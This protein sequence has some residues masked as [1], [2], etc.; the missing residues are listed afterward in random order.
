M[1]RKFVNVLI[2]LLTAAVIVV[3]YVIPMVASSYHISGLRYDILIITI[4]AAVIILASGAFEYIISL[5]LAEFLKQ[6]EQTWSTRGSLEILPKT[7]QPREMVQITNTISA[8]VAANA[9]R[10]SELQNMAG[11]TETYQRLVT[12][13]SHQMRTPVTGLNW[14][15]TSIHDDIAKGKL[16]DQSLVDEAHQA[17]ERIGTL[18]EELLVGISEQGSAKPEYR[19]IDLEECVDRI[20]SESDL[21]AKQRQIRFAVTKH[22]SPLP[23]IHGNEQ[24]IRFALHS[25]ITNAIYYSNEGGT[26]SITAES[27]GKN[28]SIT[29][30]N[31]GPAIMENEKAVIFS[32]FGRSDRAIRVNPD[33]SGLGLYLTKKIVIDHG[34]AISFESDPKTGTS[35][36][37]SFPL[38]NRGQLETFIHY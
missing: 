17:S 12:T 4:I 30:H 9:R 7:G 36:K 5:P 8:I 29:V 14:A 6:I 38:S 15:L 32:Q 27:D 22:K 16:P 28:S 26:V 35:F 10:I 19:P 34:G 23:L 2:G 11:Y 3:A 24:E 31:N 33:G 18:V 1:K 25:I 13:M 37:I 20:L 21:S